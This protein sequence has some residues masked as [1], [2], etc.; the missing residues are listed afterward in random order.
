MNTHDLRHRLRSLFQ[1]SAVERELADELAHHAALRGPLRGADAVAE[2]CRDARGVGPLETLARDLRWSWRSLF[3]APGFTIP[4]LLTLALG[5][6]ASVATYSA[7]DSIL[8][9][10]LL[11]PQADRLVLLRERLPMLSAAPL[12]VSLPDVPLM[13][14]AGTAFTG[15]GASVVGKMDLS[16]QG[17]AERI[18][19]GHISSSLFP[20]LG[21]APALGRG[22]TASEDHPGPH[23]A[24]LSDS[25]WRAHFAADPN[26]VGRAVRMDG[27]AYTVIGVM[28]RQFQYPPA[29]LARYGQ[30]AALWVPLQLTPA[31]L[32]DVGDD[33]DYAAIARLRPQATIGEAR[34]QMHAAAKAILDM[35]SAKAGPLPGLKLEVVID[36]L[37]G[38]VVAETLPL[39]RLLFL[40]AGLLMILS[41]ANVA[42]LFLVRAAGRRR[43]WA[44]RSALGAARGRIVRQSLTESA[45]LALLAAVAGLVFAQFCLAG[46]AAV[47]PS[48]LPQFQALHLSSGGFGFAALLALAIGPLCGALAARSAA[49]DGLESAL[50]SASPALAGS[51]RDARWRAALVAAQVALAFTLVC[52]A[53][54]LIRSFRSALAGGGGVDAGGRTVATIAL[55]HLEY[56]DPANVAAWADRL[57]ADLARQPGIESVAL[58][59]NQPTNDNWDHTFT[60][61]G[62]AQPPGAKLPDAQ[63]AEVIG[64]YFRTLGIPVLQGRGFTASETA[65]HAAVVIVSATLARHYWPEQNAVGRRLKWGAADSHSP[66]LTVV[67]VVGD[68]KGEAL[69]QPV[70]LT[71]YSPYRANCTA[72][73]PYQICGTLNLTA[74]SALPEAVVASQI[75][76]VV[77][78][79]D[80]SV[81]VTGVQSM[82]SLL[83]DSLVPRRFNTLLISF[84]GIAA[85]LLAAIGLYGVL[86][87]VVAGQRKEIAIRIALGARPAS[88]LSTTLRRGL[89]WSCA[90]VIAG[91]AIAFGSRNLISGLLYGTPALD[92]STWSATGALIMVTAVFACGLPAFRASRTDPQSVLR[93]G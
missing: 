76:R 1:R 20:L 47:A 30:P 44:M 87:F 7:A 33:F 5:L 48:T 24:I 51:S 46:L 15:V 68:V 36:P 91:A 35:W 69:D 11:Y 17:A 49:G 29:G 40:A 58:A 70:S 71:T 64:P 61:E 52:G 41:C 63:S 4:A 90:G 45:L 55:P 66:W 77:A 18:S 65:G 78:G 74:H 53:G 28:P 60:V 93:Q 89:A 86:A 39:M 25:F 2:A 75:R 43:E 84:F 13:A 82:A 72:D 56:A 8:L 22:F 23:V 32:A 26:V 73:A 62:R 79:I 16:G 31:Q 59:T 42:N 88:V 81:P 14:E 57:R 54:L 67:G 85:L 12:R 19:V 92:L 37:A 9:H 38:Q 21:V 80:P 34:A 3:H 6:G 10:P 83:D 27:S 50:R